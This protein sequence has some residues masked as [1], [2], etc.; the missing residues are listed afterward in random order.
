M[1]FISILLF[2]CCLHYG[3]LKRRDRK[4]VQKTKFCI[5]LRESANL[6]YQELH[7][8]CREHSTSKV[9]FFRWQ[10]LFLKSREAVDDQRRGLEHK[11]SRKIWNVVVKKRV[12]FMSF[13]LSSGFS[14]IFRHEKSVFQNIDK[15][16]ILLNSKPIGTM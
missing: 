5:M 10:E 4:S 3:F 16:T 1:V 2:S 7:C 6:N 15:N 9:Q 13:C 12:E 8:S 14:S 11:K